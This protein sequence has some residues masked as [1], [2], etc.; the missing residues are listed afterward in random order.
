MVEM[1]SDGEYEIEIREKLFEANEVAKKEYN[2]KFEPALTKMQK[3]YKELEGTK[4]FRGK[5]KEGFMETFEMLLLYH[6][7]L[8]EHLSDLYKAI[9]T[10]KE[11]LDNFEKDSLYTSLK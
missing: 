4:G 3:V 11:D 1:M 6:E 8:K 2:D 5:A 7:D 9:D 10:L